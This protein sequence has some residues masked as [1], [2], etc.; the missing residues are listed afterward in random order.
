MAIYSFREEINVMKLVGAS[1]WFIRGPFFVMGTIVSLMSAIL[2]FLVMWLSIAIASPRLT[3]FLPEI[4]LYGFFSREWFV[5]FLVELVTGIAVMA[6]S[7]Y[8]ATNK[9]LKES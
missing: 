4:S 2:V 6:V 7:T 9:Y 3:N 1:K 5:M 8:L